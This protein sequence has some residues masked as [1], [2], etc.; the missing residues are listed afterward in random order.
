MQHANYKNLGVSGD[1]VDGVVALKHDAEVA[2][3]LIA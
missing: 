1:V 3:Q 2:R